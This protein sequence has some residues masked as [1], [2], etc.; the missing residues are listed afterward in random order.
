MGGTAMAEQIKTRMTATEFL[1]LP[2]TNLPLQLLDGEVVTEMNAPE[3][4]H[5]DVVGNVFVLFKLKAR[6][7][8]GKAYVAPVDVYF[9]ELNIPQPDVI[10]LASDTRC[11]M[12]GTQRLSGAPDLIAEVLSPSTAAIDRKKKFRLYEKY[13]VREYWIVEPRD[14]LVEVWQQHVN[15]FVL[16]DAY[17]SSESFTSSLIG[18]VK[19]G[20]LFES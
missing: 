10:W 7:L 9:D 14:Q 20:A 12:V 11:E 4:P 19:V 5:Q 17:A 3:L 18:E 1:Q 8:G 2:E 16:L 6:E 13:G 15:H